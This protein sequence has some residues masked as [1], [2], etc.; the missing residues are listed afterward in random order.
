MSDAPF[1]E[2]LLPAAGQSG[3]AAAARERLRAALAKLD[4]AGGI[5]DDG[6]GTGRHA[7]RLLKPAKKPNA[8]A[9]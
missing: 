3:A 6:D 1:A 9:E 2:N 4:P 7:N 8:A 5:L